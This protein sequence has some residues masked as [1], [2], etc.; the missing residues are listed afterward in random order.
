MGKGTKTGSGRTL[1]AVIVGGVGA[2]LA[3][4]GGMV[5]VLF[6]RS[7]EAERIRIEQMPPSSAAALRETPLGQ[8]VLLEGHIA[9]GQPVLFRDFVA[10][11]RQQRRRSEDSNN[12]WQTKER[13]TPSL[14]IDVVGGQVQLVNSTYD[15]K[16][17]LTTWQESGL[18]SFT[19]GHVSGLV[20]REAVI[21]VG[22]A[23]PGGGIDAEFVTPGTQQSY[24]L[25]LQESRKVSFWL[26]G[27]LAGLGALLVAVGTG[28][29]LTRP[30]RK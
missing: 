8:A 17:S 23:G 16:G 15:M 28:L 25:G 3:I 26:G 9:A 29:A 6:P 5:A 7:L 12:S 30:R 14:L 20:A 2:V 21:V 22:R 10:Y 19:E 4:A 18:D 24:V 13:E 1:A 27:G 11:S